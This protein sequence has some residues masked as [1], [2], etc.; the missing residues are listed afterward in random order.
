MSRRILG[1]HFNSQGKPK[2]GYTSERVAKREA[3]RFGMSHY[4]CDVCD[5]FHLTKGDDGGGRGN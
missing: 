5:R 2:R 1:S 4:R 3:A